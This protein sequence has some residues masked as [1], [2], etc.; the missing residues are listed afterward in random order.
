M[1]RLSEELRT[2]ASGG[3]AEDVS[4]GKPG[5]ESSAKIFGNVEVGK[6]KERSSTNLLFDQFLAIVGRQGQKP[7]VVAEAVELESESSMNNEDD[8]AVERK[9][10]VIEQVKTPLDVESLGKL[11]LNELDEMKK[12]A[13]RQNLSDAEARAVLNAYSVSVSNNLKGARKAKKEAICKQSKFAAKAVSRKRG[14]GDEVSSSGA[15]TE[16]LTYICSEGEE[17]TDGSYDAQRD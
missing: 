8:E 5:K 13:N 17:E 6:A 10:A 16:A 11:S 12:Y 15:D 3:K 7:T 14:G 9:D 1:W 4:T 2:K